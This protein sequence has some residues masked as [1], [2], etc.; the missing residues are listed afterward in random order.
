MWG[1]LADDT[2]PVGLAAYAA[3]AIA[4]SDPIK[5][6]IQSFFYDVRTAILP[7]LFVLN[8]DLILLNVSFIEGIFIFIFGIFGIVLF[9]SMLQ[10]YFI[11]RNKLFEIPFF[12]FGSLCLLYPAVFGDREIFYLV[13]LFVFIGLVVSQKIREKTLAKDV[14]E[15]IS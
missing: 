8:T 11:V 7:F 6:G 12:L 15:L 9:E 14:S 13:G 3:S 4:K 2:S 5:T 1:I 10:N